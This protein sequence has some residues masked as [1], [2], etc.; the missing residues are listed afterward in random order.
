MQK[1]AK[2]NFLFLLI[3]GLPLAAAAHSWYPEMCCHENDC[4]PID[5]SERRADGS[6]WVE[7]HGVTI[8]VP[9]NFPTQPSLDNEDHICFYFN[10][11]L[12]LYLPKC[13]FRSAQS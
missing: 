3:L 11:D 1:L 4:F 13:L 2:S 7:A 8:L 9:A 6:F 12:Q 5:R 10:M